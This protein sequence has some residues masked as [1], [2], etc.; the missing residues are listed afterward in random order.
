MKEFPDEILYNGLLADIY[1]FKGENQKALEVYNDLLERNPDNPQVQL[2]VCDFLI[3][4][5][6]YEDLF[7]LLN[8]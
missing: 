7:S 6:S 2:S 8:M 3:E 1:K 5:K 4:E